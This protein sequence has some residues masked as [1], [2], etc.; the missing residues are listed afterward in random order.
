MDITIKDILGDFFTNYNKLGEFKIK[1]D[2]DMSKVDKELA[3]YYH[4]IEG[5]HLSHNTQGHSLILELQE[6]LGRRREI[7]KE[8]L[9]IRSFL[10]V[11]A[12][13]MGT[14]RKRNK[15]IVKVHNKMVRKMK[16]KSN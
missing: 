3:E 1:I 15:N 11:T 6:I 5:I 7:K 16:E 10:D 8:S 4:K 13:S 14:A 2:S 9:L 12:D